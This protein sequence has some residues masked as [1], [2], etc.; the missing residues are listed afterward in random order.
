MK[1]PAAFSFPLASYPGMNRFALDMVAGRGSA[2]RFVT[3]IASED[4][5]PGNHHRDRD[6]V[7]ALELTNQGWGNDVARSLAA[8]QRGETLTLIAG[9][10]VGFGGG[11]LYTFA[12]IASL[13]KI[14]QRLELLGKASTVFFWMATEDHDLDEIATL[15]MV[16]ADGPSKFRS[17]ERGQ[18]KSVGSLPLP[19]DLRK[20]LAAMPEFAAAPWLREGMSF[21]DSFA[22]LLGGAFRGRIVLIDSLLPSLRKLGQGLFKD[23]VRSIDEANAIVATR[24]AEVEAAGYSAQIVRREDEPY[25]FLF[26]IDS[27]GDRKTVQKQ[28]DGWS[29]GGENVSEDE[30][31]AII[32]SSPESISTGAL[33]RPL[34]Q[35][36]VFGPDVFV[37]G[38]AEVAYYAQL[39]GLYEHFHVRQPHVALRGHALI[40]SSKLMRTIE[41]HDIEPTELFEPVEELIA[42]RAPEAIAELNR[43]ADH[44]R[45]TLEAELEEIERLVLPADR[46][47]Q[48]SI[49][50]SRRHLEYHL[51][52]MIERGERAIVRRDG[53]RYKA[54][55]RA[56]DEL[57]PNG[58]AQDRVVSWLPFWLEYGSR[59]VDRMVEE[60]APD[61]DTGVV[62]RI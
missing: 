48:R 47:L 38:P 45:K 27:S 60:I 43:A 62:V 55:S 12:K 17:E 18:G 57:M 59:L 2:T 9:Q 46:S 49:Q 19:E 51:A 4:L 58:V 53:E 41:K 7:R 26:H 11:P 13:L 6:L 3:R 1:S 20:S 31:I 22:T 16:R 29:I 14:Q 34:L 8:W 42:R 54:F 40:G 39:G 50:R 30:L 21:R 56:H 15:F 28:G 44:A 32:E 61:S 25:P 37:G 36:L 33:L 5:Q 10:Q 23:V 35:D 24:S 52:K